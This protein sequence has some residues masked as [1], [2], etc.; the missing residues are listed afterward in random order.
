MVPGGDA[1]SR[2]EVIAQLPELTPAELNL[3]ICRLAKRA[4]G[5][6]ALGRTVE[7]LQ[8][9]IRLTHEQLT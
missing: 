8:Q 5:L 1:R 6:N 4:G 9:A 3:E 2:E 7:S